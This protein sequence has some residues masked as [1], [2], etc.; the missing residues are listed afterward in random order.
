M[1][2]FTPTS[3][4]ANARHLFSAM[5][6]LSYIMFY[7]IREVLAP[8]QQRSNQ[9]GAQP[10]T[11]GKLWKA[12]QG[13][14]KFDSGLVISNC[15]HRFLTWFSREKKG[16]LTKCCAL[17]SL[18][19]QEFEDDCSFIVCLDLSYFDQSREQKCK[20][21]QLFNPRQKRRI[22]KV[23][24]ILCHGFSKKES[25]DSKPNLR[26]GIRLYIIIVLRFGKRWQQMIAYL[27]FMYVPTYTCYY[28]FLTSFA[29]LYPPVDVASRDGRFTRAS[30]FAHR[31][32]EIAFNPAAR[33]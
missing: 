30:A 2:T 5:S 26:S 21:S 7:K 27:P 23:L 33:T 9:N 22:I 4:L 29:S 6:N 32:E 24:S 31:R 19:L 1:A 14:P 15:I 8:L 17:P 3:C 10:H 13:F 11:L 16:V 25:F 28:G 12:N 18:C 20:P